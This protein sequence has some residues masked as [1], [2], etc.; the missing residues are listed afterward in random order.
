MATVDIANELRLLVSA[1][2]R[3]SGPCRQLF[4]RFDLDGSGTI[5]VDE[6]QQ[7]LNVE[8]VAFNERVREKNVPPV[9]VPSE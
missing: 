8:L 6:L 5:S 4:A 9:L 7:V 2:P 1:S 3:D